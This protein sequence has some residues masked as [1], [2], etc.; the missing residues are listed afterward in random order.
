MA[1]QYVLLKYPL[2][3][4]RTDNSFFT[5]I[6]VRCDMSVLERELPSFHR[7]IIQH[8]STPDGELAQDNA[9]VMH[10]INTPGVPFAMQSSMQLYK[11]EWID[12]RHAELVLGLGFK[13]RNPTIRESYVDADL[14]TWWAKALEYT[15]HNTVPEIGKAIRLYMDVLTVYDRL[16]LKGT[17]MSRELPMPIPRQEVFSI[18][19]SSLVKKH[20]CFKSDTPVFS[21]EAKKA[22]VRDDSGHKVS[23]CEK[24]KASDPNIKLLVCGKCKAA[25]YCSKEC[26]RDH[27]DEHKSFCKAICEEAV[28][29]LGTPQKHYRV[30]GDDVQREAKVE[31]PEGEIIMDQIKELFSHTCL[32]CYGWLEDVTDW[33]EGAG[34]CSRVCIRRYRARWG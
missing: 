23:S 9:V 4:L 34:C 17:F 26:Q 32:H 8:E 29:N 10:F 13:L 30:Q 6:N 24:C 3:D 22:V 14:P 11:I 28:T 20:H 5:R 1:D 27:W 31:G 25:R 15:E 2:E 21:T 18:S 33:G 19:I 12:H 7:S 16:F